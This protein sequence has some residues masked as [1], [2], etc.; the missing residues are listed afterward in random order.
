M[1]TEVMQQCLLAANA[2]ALPIVGLKYGIRPL[3]APLEERVAYLKSGLD[4]I[5][6][7]FNV[8]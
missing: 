8:R 7:A 2:Q 3:E 6:A 4:I 1:T 5:H